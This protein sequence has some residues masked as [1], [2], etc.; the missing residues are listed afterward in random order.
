[1][2]DVATRFDRVASDFAAVLRSAPAD[3]WGNPSPCEGWTALDVVA[4]LTEW[5][6][7]PG[8]LLGTYGIEPGTIPAIGDDPAGAWD[9][10]RAAIQAGL[11]GPTA[12]HEAD[13]GPLGY[14]TFED[15]VAL[16]VIGD[17]FIHT[18]D[19]ARAAGVEVVLDADE[20][21]RQ[22]DAVAAVPADVDAAMRRSGHYG[23]R[24]ALADD[25][26]PLTTV[27][28]FYGRRSTDCTTLTRSTR[29]PSSET[30]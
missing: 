15:A 5:I 4:H 22:H 21:R 11:D 28:A 20:L 1:M 9:V 27:L 7:G 2:P 18:W 10:V 29:S 25:A 8:F 14:R 24:V 6:P 17:V 3:A 16:T 30:P 19:L 26:D 23:P 12:T 13:C